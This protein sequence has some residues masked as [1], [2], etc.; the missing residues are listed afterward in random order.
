[1]ITAEQSVELIDMLAE[2]YPVQI[3]VSRDSKGY[4]NWG[5]VCFHCDVDHPLP[6]AIV[7]REQALRNHHAD[8]ALAWIN[9]K[10]TEAR[11]AARGRLLCLAC[12]HRM[13]DH[14]GR[15][16]SYGCV[17]EPSF[18]LVSNEAAR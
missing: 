18:T 1:M 15:R 5:F 17:C 6:D 8:L 12:N 9:E 7:A 14:D 10:L 4:A 2:H 16:C 13:S 11:R 3:A